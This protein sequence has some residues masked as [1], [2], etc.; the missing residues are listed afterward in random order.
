M[1]VEKLKLKLKNAMNENF[2]KLYEQSN[3]SAIG[4]SQIIGVS[5]QR[6]YNI[7]NNK[8]ILRETTYYKYKIKFLK[9]QKR[10]T[11]KQKLIKEFLD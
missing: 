3:Y 10:I 8:Q 7:I 11:K 1:V 9:N 4:F 2:R 5:R 6:F